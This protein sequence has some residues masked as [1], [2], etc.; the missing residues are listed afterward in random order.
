MN[1]FEK[2]LGE[3]GTERKRSRFYLNLFEGHRLFGLR[4]FYFNKKESLER[5][6]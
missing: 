1:N 4:E 5:Y 2:I 6:R 3:E